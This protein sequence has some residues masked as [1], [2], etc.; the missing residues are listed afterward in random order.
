MPDDPKARLPFD[1]PPVYFFL[2]ILLIIA[3]HRWLPIADLIDPPAS[4]IGYVPIIA[5]IALAAWGRWRFARA[6]TNVVPFAPSTAL[7]ADGPF[8]FTRNPMYLGMML[9]L[10]GLVIL[11]GS[12]SG[13]LVVAAFLGLIRTRFVLPEEDHMTDHFGEAYQAYQQRV[14]RWL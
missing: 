11:T 4:R 12:L 7:V 3:L 9:V 2:A 5:G 6:G 14:R 10:L 13:I 1:V 8:Q